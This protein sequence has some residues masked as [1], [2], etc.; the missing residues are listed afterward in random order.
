MEVPP[1]ER[2]EYCDIILKQVFDIATSKHNILFSSFD[3]H[4]CL[5]VNLKQQVYPVLFLTG[6]GN[7]SYHLDPVTKSLRQALRFARRYN[8][9]G[10]VSHTRCLCM[11]PQ[12]I[13]A[14]QDSGLYLFSYGAENN[15]IEKVELQRK[16][17]LT[18]VIC[19]HVRHIVERT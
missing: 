12:I 18:A 17:G 8:L 6:S 9:M 19:D 10:V 4:I 1:I 16:A 13:K 3:P 5:L 2:N 15:D 7:Y 14:A 11:E